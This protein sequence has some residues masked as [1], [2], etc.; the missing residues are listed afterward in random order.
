MD[1]GELVEGGTEGMAMMVRRLE[2]VGVHVIGAYLI[3]STSTDGSADAALRIVTNDDAR[4]VVH[5][6]V[7]LRRDGLLPKI[8]DDVTMMPVTP[9][10]VEASRVLDYAIQL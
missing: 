4:D 2:S 5:K 6:Y 9:S 10:D 8:S 3:R 7:R 1:T